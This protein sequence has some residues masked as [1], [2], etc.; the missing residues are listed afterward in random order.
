MKTGE[1]ESLPSD[2]CV[3]KARFGA[4][5]PPKTAGVSAAAAAGE[6]GACESFMI[7]YIT[8][9]GLNFQYSHGI[10]ANTNRRI[11]HKMSKLSYVI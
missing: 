10:A 9:I 7:V 4:P 8:G 6:A 3:S 1:A 11:I 5:L 2:R